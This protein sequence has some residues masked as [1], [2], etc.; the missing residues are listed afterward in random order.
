MRA[1]WRLE[2][3]SFNLIPDTS[4]HFPTSNDCQ[5]RLKLVGRISRAAI[6]MH[7]TCLDSFTIQEST[8]NDLR[9][10]TDAAM[11]LAGLDVKKALEGRE[12][13]CQHS[14]LY[15]MAITGSLSNFL[16]TIRSPR[17]STDITPSSSGIKLAPGHL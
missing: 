7:S 6:K 15:H 13:T 5:G 3:P 9:S 17:S 2:R 14:E 8:S 12:I 16:I 1:Q 11:S 10:R 4:N